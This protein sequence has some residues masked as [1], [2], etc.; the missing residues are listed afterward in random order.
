[1]KCYCDTIYTLSHDLKIYPKYRLNFG[2][3]WFSK[4]FLKKYQTKSVFEIYDALN[5]NKYVK[6]IKFFESNKHLIIGYTI[7]Q[8]DKKDCKYLA[9]H[10]K[11][12]GSTFTFKNFSDDMLANLVVDPYCVHGDQFI[13][14][15]SAEDLLDIASKIDDDSAF[16]EKIKNCA[17]QINEQDNPIAVSFKLKEKPI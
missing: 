16:S 7:Q 15:I 2:E 4:E 17:K 9:I 12:K 3:N 14:L 13:S 8:D 6:F 10:F 11:S 5:R 1:M